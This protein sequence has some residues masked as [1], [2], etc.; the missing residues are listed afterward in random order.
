[1]PFSLQGPFFISFNRNTLEARHVVS[2]F[3]VLGRSIYRAAFQQPVPSP[4]YFPTSH[5]PP[6]AAETRGKVAALC[7]LD[8]GQ[9]WQHSPYQ[10]SY[11]GMLIHLWPLKTQRLFWMSYNRPY[12]VFYILKHMHTTVVTFINHANHPHLSWTYRCVLCLLSKWTQTPH[13][14]SHKAFFSHHY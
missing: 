1:M 3:A 14:P 13:H 9:N 10:P 6:C 4:S 8:T 12:S 2:T 7:R 5:D 11:A